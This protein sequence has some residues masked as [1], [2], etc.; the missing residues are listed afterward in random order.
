M[1]SLRHG[2]LVVLSGHD[3]RNSTV[4][5]RDNSVEKDSASRAYSGSSRDRQRSPGVVKDDPGTEGLGEEKA[6]VRTAIVRVVVTK[7]VTRDHVMLALPLRLYMGFEVHSRK[8]TSSFFLLFHIMDPVDLYTLGC[9]L[10]L[11]C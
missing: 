6:G 3:Y 4:E 5:S 11:E 9:G 8:T 2:Q 1:A 10:S 7:A